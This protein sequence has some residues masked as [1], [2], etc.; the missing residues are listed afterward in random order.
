MCLGRWF[1]RPCRGG[2]M[3][4]FNLAYFYMLGEIIGQLQQTTLAMIERPLN[5]LGWTA[6]V[7]AHNHIHPQDIKGMLPQCADLA[8]DILA[9]VAPVATNPREED[10]VV[11]DGSI[12]TLSQLLRK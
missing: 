2:L 5:R 6:F 4:E 11:Y 10:G 3:D 7:N 12:T 8:T 9:L 1:S